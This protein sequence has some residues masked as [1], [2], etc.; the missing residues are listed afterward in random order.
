MQA[1]TDRTGWTLHPSRR[2]VVVSLRWSVLLLLL[3]IAVYGTTN[4]L[5]AQRSDRL[6][7]WFDWELG[8][9]LLPWM[10][11]PYLSLLASFFLPMFVLREAAIHA[12]CR[13]LALATVISGI[14]FLLAPGELGFTR[15]A[16]VP[17]HDAAFR[18]I[19]TLDLPHN[20]AP[21]LH[22]SWSLILLLTLRAASP[23]WARR[24][25]ELWLALL[26]ASVLFTHQHHVLD[27][28][29]GMLVALIARVVVRGDGSWIAF[30]G[31][32]P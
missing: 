18:L 3:F 31:R 17:G 13:R 16:A 10:V 23:A 7:L 24:L 27:F 9:P 11:W 1:I 28:A 2:V 30:N 4:W 22:V 29:G 25:F 26:L 12:L 21:S 20:L 6:M 15:T 8:I 19:H 14:C 5:T 32:A